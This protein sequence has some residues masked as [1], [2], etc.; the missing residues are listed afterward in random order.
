MDVGI[1]SLDTTVMLGDKKDFSGSKYTLGTLY[2]NN[3]NMNVSGHLNIYNPSGTE[4]TALAFDLTVPWLSLETLSWG[5]PDGLGGNSSAGYVGLRNLAIHN[6]AITGRAEVETLTVPSPDYTG[7]LPDG[8]VFVRL[9]FSE[10]DVRLD[11]LNTEVALGPTKDN[12]NQVLGSVYLGGLQTNINGSVD[13]HT[14]SS[15][16]QGIVFDLNLSP[17]NVRAAAFSWG[18]NDGFSG[19]SVAGFRGWRNMEIN[20]LTV[21]G[22]VEIEVATINSSVPPVSLNELMFASYKIPKMSPSFVH[23]G[24]GTGNATDDP[25][26]PG[27]LAIGINSLSWDVVLDTS[28]SLD[29]ANKGVLR[30]FYMSDFTARVNG[31]VHVGAH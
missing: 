23:L 14:P 8:T 29:S 31:W 5:D 24:L 26:L 21:K 2:M 16:T 1:I 19:G 18:D 4:A 22:P 6:L 13:I 27:A 12:L 25:A 9:G 7:N 10:L 28:R 17:T 20:G 15:S 3:L 30:S 11:S